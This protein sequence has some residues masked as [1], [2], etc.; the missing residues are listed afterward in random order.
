M[1]SGP[2]G[3]WMSSARSLRDAPPGGGV[4]KDC[5]IDQLPLRDEWM[6]CRLRWVAE[7]HTDDVAAAFTVPSY[8]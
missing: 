4:E 6:K 2:S 7:R 5:R 1:M 3:E 8:S